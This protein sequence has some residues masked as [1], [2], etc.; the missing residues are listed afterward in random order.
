MRALGEFE[1]F[2]SKECHG[3]KE[4]EV[5]KAVDIGGAIDP[6][7]V[8]NGDLGNFKIELGGAKEKIEITEGIE[9]TEEFSVLGNFVI[10]AFAEGF[11]AAQG[12]FDGLIQEIGE[13][14]TK[15]FVAEVV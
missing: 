12:V 14:K 5:D 1:F 2:G 9:I 7:F 15:K 3:E 10:V 11:G 6:F 4:P 13:G 8:T